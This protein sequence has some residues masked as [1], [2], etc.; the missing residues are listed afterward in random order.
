MFLTNN[1]GFRYER[2]EKIL[3]SNIFGRMSLTM[4]LTMHPMIDLLINIRI[5]TVF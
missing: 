3:P 2:K 1:N 5:K 4:I